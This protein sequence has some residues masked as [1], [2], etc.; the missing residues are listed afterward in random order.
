MTLNDPQKY[1]HH[2]RV[3]NM[4]NAH[5]QFRKP[6]QKVL[7]KVTNFLEDAILCLSISPY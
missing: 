6:K 1:Y 3:F 7:E 2:P 4:R 5:A